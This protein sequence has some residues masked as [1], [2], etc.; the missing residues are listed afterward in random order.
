MLEESKG[1]N[2][3]KQKYLLLEDKIKGGLERVALIPCVLDNNVFNDPVLNTEQR[4][5]FYRGHGQR[6]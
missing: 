2:A 3:F 5:P 6:K 1:C 4:L